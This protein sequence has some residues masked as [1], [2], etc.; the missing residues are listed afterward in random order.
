ME[1]LLCI[2]H[3]LHAGF[4]QNIGQTHQAQLLLNIYQTL[5]TQFGDGYYLPLLSQKD[6]TLYLVKV[7]FFKKNYD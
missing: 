7:Y 3:E 5:R 4:V 6:A 2:C 1:W